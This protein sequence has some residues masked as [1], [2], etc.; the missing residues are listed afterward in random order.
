MSIRQMSFGQANSRC[1][2]NRDF[3]TLAPVPHEEKCTPAGG[4][5][6][7]HIAEC[8]ALVGQLIRIHGEPP[9]GAEFVLIRNDHEV[10]EYWEVGIFYQKPDEDAG[11]DEI[12]SPSLVYAQKLEVGIPNNWDEQAVN[13]MKAAGHSSFKPK[14][15]AK[16]VKH[17]GKIVKIN[18]E[19]A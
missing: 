9:E 2:E 17:Q 1:N 3:F 8:T 11:G 16:V 19:T 6:P 18:S 15:P 7:D 14:E 10:G 5:R 12:E 4:D 13:E